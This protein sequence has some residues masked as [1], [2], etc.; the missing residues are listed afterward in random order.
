[1]S[2]QDNNWMIKAPTPEDATALAHMHAESFKAAYLSEDAVRNAKVLA[3]AAQFITL[4]RIQARMELLQRSLTHT[5]EE[6][7]S[8]ATDAATVPIGLIYGYTTDEAQDLSALYVDPSYF[9]TG[10]AQELTKA[11]I[12][13]CD[14]ERPIELGVVEDNLR[15]Q[16]FYYKMGFR[17]VTQPHESHYDYLHEIKM[18]LPV[19]EEK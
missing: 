3:Q 14:K 2:T 5:D 15:A 12:D 7:Y 18:I 9:G 17:A 19:K 1:M 6:F 4:E 13:W 8:I 16:K 10:L 11:F